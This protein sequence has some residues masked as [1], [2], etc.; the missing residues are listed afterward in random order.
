MNRLLIAALL[1]APLLAHADAYRCKQ[2][3]GSTS[4][5]DHPCPGTAKGG[6][7]NLPT[8]QGYAPPA[9]APK[10]DDS[11]APHHTPGAAQNA[12]V[13]QANAQIRALNSEARAAHCN[14]ARRNL[15]TLNDQVRVYSRGDDGQRQYMDDKDRP[16][17]IAAAQQQVDEN[18]N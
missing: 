12:A 16:A 3:D 11:S 5:Q 14:T 1:S 7:Y 17:A 4:Y 10:P 8:A 15:G 13:D 6:S 9:A 2:P 18:C